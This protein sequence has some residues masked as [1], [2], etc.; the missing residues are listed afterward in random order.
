MQNAPLRNSNQMKLALQ[1]QQDQTNQSQNQSA[2]NTIQDLNLKLGEII[3]NNSR[4]YGN[5]FDSTNFGSVVNPSN[6]SNE[7]HLNET[8]SNLANFLTFLKKNPQQQKMNDIPEIVAPDPGYHTHRYSNTLTETQYRNLGMHQTASVPNTY[9]GHEIETVPLTQQITYHSRTNSQHASSTKTNMSRKP[10]PS[11]TATGGGGVQHNNFVST[12]RFNSVESSPYKENKT[13]YMQSST[14]M[15]MI[16]AQTKSGNNLVSKIKNF[17]EV[18]R[19]SDQNAAFKIHSTQNSQR[20]LSRE[21]KR[22]SASNHHYNTSGKNSL[23]KTPKNIDSGSREPSMSKNTPFTGNVGPGGIN[24]GA[25]LT[26][27]TSRLNVKQTES[28]AR[29]NASNLG[30]T[31]SSLKSTIKVDYATIVHTNPSATQANFFKRENTKESTERGLSAGS[32]THSDKQMKKTHS[33][34]NSGN[35]ATYLTNSVKTQQAL[36]SGTKMSLPLTSQALFG[37][38]G[39]NAA[40]NVHSNP[41]SFRELKSRNTYYEHRRQPS[42]LVGSLSKRDLN[43]VQQ[44]NELQKN[45]PIYSSREAVNRD[46]AEPIVIETIN[47]ARPATMHKYTKSESKYNK[48]EPGFRVD[49]PP[50]SH[51]KFFQEGTQG[52]NRPSGGKGS[53]GGTT[54]L[55]ASPAKQIYTYNQNNIVNIFLN[56]DAK[57]RN[58]VIKT[59]TDRYGTNGSFVPNQQEYP[60][61]KRTN[62]KKGVSPHVRDFINEPM[63]PRLN[64]NLNS[65]PYK[66]G[67]KEEYPYSARGNYKLF[68]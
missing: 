60:T 55:N 36:A 2:S 68:C 10:Y 21:S 52:V 31:Q 45:H 6:S 66:V 57:D 4:N 63:D 22:A 67:K 30:S 53:Y 13:D 35:V 46:Y 20:S 24:I 38:G 1:D 41:Q 16:R 61:S 15:G 25:S 34:M 44:I 27:S 7:P 33:R 51:R 32:T 5:Y 65:S 39:G 18:L 14:G 42:S 56:Q 64:V 43:L 23:S 37:N 29:A 50:L 48:M 62:T 17:D 9:R 3:S 12:E 58:I 28:T 11:S 40:A 47:S 59:E 26:K 54:N 49:E 8:I 19:H